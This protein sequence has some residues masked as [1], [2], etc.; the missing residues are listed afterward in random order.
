M[1]T[2]DFAVQ[3]LEALYRAGHEILLVVTQPDRPRGRHGELQKSAVRIA[4]EAHGTEVITPEK[5]RRDEDAKEKMRALK[6]DVIVVAA[7]GQILPEDVLD[8]PKYGCINVH[9]S[10]LLKYRGAAPIQWAVLNGDREAG[11][12][13]MMMDAGLDTGDMLESKKIQLDRK[14]TGGSLFDKLAVLGGELITETLRHLA[15]G[16][17]KRTPQDPAEATKV[18]MFRRD[19]GRIDWK[20][21]AEVIERKV[22]G[23]NPWPTAFAFLS[24]RTMK[25]WDTDVMDPEEDLS[26][27]RPAARFDDTD[28]AAGTIY[29]DGKR[30]YVVCGEG[31]LQINELQLEGKKRM[32]TGEFLRGHRFTA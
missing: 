29:T 1:G 21:S 2:P 15:E 7:F 5:I 18:G 24:G 28:T 16:T 27:F 6:P 9:A 23:L 11:V 4:A 22:R 12:T 26:G 30:M 19:S 32:K 17:L 8:I 10:L 14:E 25:L 31:N 20:E 3:T 13:T